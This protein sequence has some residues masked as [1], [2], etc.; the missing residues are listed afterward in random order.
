M[1]ARTH[2]RYRR[3]S[4]TARGSRRWW[5]SAA[6]LWVSEAWHHG[7]PDA[8]LTDSRTGQ[9]RT[10]NESGKGD[11][12][13]IN[14]RRQSRRDTTSRRGPD[15]VLVCVVRVQHHLLTRNGQRAAGLCSTRRHGEGCAAGVQVCMCA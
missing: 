11:E 3:G 15:H 9:D 13:I 2:A 7:L 1:H 5:N 14:S 12:L 10:A 4:A 6:T 8:S